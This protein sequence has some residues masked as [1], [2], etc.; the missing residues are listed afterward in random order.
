MI[1]TLE[2][3]S[4]N[5]W[6]APQTAFMDGW[7]LRFAHG[8][9]RRANSINPLFPGRQ[10]A[11]DKIAACEELYRERG[12]NVTFKLTSAVEPGDL[13]GILEQAGYQLDAPTSV[14]TLDLAAFGG[15]PGETISLAPSL[16]ETWLESYARFSGVQERNR[17]FLRQI[18]EGILPKHCFAAAHQG[19]KPVAC[20]MGVVQDGWIG[21]YDIVTAPDYRQQGIGRQIVSGL[22]AW[23]KA[24]GARRAYLQVMLNNPPALR[25]YASL[26]FT[27]CYQYWYR[28]KK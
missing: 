14:Q 6:P 3:L 18:L 4:L 20:G 1:R 22:L 2:E 12:L 16:N 17:P 28:V 27:E 25:L 15:S 21:L 7:V 24:H 9:T 8:Y 11:P 23:G 5:A 13:D 10:A 19:S 26:G